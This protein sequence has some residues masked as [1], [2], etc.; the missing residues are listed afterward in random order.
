MTIEIDAYTLAKAP[1]WRE[2]LVLLTYN[3]SKA[4][5]FLEEKGSEELKNRFRKT[6]ESCYLEY[7]DVMR[8][9][10]TYDYATK[11]FTIHEESFSSMEEVVEYAA[12]FF[13]LQK[14]KKPRIAFWKRPV[15]YTAEEAI[16][17]LK[18]KK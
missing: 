9:H 11:R 14:T 6:E 3:E 10:V 8:V 5:D 4:D 13:M 17:Y 18:E 15:Y 16:A 7:G 2:E 12:K 1:K